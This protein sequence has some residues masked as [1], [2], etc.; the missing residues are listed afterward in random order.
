MR[1]ATVAA[2]M[3]AGIVLPSIGR[4]ADT[5]S[6]IPR[7]VAI[8]QTTA[9]PGCT[10]HVDAAA[11]DGGDGSAQSPHKTIAAAVAAASPAPS[12]ASPRAPTPSRSRRARNT[13]RSPAVSSAAAASRCAT[14]ANYVSKAQGSGQGSFLR[15]ADPGPKGG[16]LTAI[17]GFEITGYSQA[18][19]RD[20]LRVAALRPHQQ[21]H[22]RQYVRRSR[23]LSAPASRSTTSRARSAATSFR[24]NACG[25]GGGGFLNDA[26]NKNTVKIE[27][28]LVDGNSGTEPD[29]VARRRVLLGGNTLSIVGNAFVEQHRDAVGRRALCRRLYGGQSVDDGDARWNVYRGNSA[30]DWRRRLLLRRRR[31]V[32]RLARGLRPQLRRQRPARRR[33]GRLGPDPRH[34]RPR[35]QRR[36]ARRRMRRAGHRRFRRHLRRLRRRHLFVHELAVLE[37]RARKGFR[38]GV[39][40]WL[41]CDQGRC[42][43]SLMQTNYAK[44]GGIDITFG[45]GMIESVD[46]MFVAPDK[47][48]FHLKPGSP[49]VRQGKRRHR[50]W[51]VRVRWS[52]GRR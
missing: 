17:D 11:E 1:R 26:T 6:E 12:S 5:P 24:K 3:L 52:S 43:L 48:D 14:R 41:R 10:L 22:P 20:Y 32:H 27:N 15:I 13:S 25:R 28:N 8:A 4:A 36:R 46:P 35:D 19:V 31:N 2:V 47:G 18:I 38:D 9:I 39:R 29:A 16:Q 40:K 37:Q 30:G 33:R 44:D 7:A 51:R 23:R 34:V 42:V 49:A 21:L 50:P 45:A